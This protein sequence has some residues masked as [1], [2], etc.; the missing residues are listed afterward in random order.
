MNK[1]YGNIWDAIASN[2][3]EAS[4]YA[5]EIYALT[6]SST[7]SP[8]Y[9]FIARDLIKLAEQLKLPEDERDKNYTGETLDIIDR[10][11]IPSRF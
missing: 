3:Q 11:N 6:I 10:K 5:K 7:Y 8:K 2:R 4:K 9:F 1:T